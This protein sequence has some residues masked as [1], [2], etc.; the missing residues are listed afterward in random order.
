M[1]ISRTQ[2]DDVVIIRL[3]GDVM[4]GPEASRLHEEV[5][6][7]L[8]QESMKAI[9]DLSEVKRMNSSGLG[10]LINA[11]TTFRQ[12]GGRLVLA[13]LT[14]LVQNLLTITRLNTVFESYESVEAAVN[15]F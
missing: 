4:G 12:N 7:L 2:Q 11:N 10:I 6:S 1:K 9:L 15:A 14:P 13:G 3:E 8:D 5:N